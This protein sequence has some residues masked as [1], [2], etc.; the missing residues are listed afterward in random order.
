MPSSKYAERTITSFAYGT[1]EVGIN[2][3]LLPFGN[4]KVATKLLSSLLIIH[5]FKSVPTRMVFRNMIS[6]I[7]SCSNDL[8]R[9]L[10]RIF[11]SAGGTVVS[12]DFGMA[13]S[14]VAYTNSY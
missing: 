9:I 13:S 6:R 3:F 2:V 8:S 4:F 10:D 11:Q 5:T 1:C 12:G 7:L 14:I